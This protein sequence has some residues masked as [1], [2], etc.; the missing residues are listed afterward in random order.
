MNDKK[1]TVKDITVTALMAALVFAGTYYLKIPIP[2]MGGYIHLGDSMIFLTVCILG[3]KEGAIAGAIGAALADLLGGYAIWMVPTFFIKAIMALIMG[4]LA[5][6]SHRTYGWVAGCLAGCIFQV[7]AYS[8]ATAFLF[9]K[10]SAL[11]M[12]TGNTVQSLGGFLVAFAVF[13]VM[14]NA[15]LVAAIKRQ[16]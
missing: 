16:L 14:H 13:T 8:A 6:R 4:V 2:A 5:E 3:K 7:A 11:A 9:D 12:I 15:G 1:M 10:A